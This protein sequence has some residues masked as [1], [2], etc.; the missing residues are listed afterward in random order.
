M[1][2]EKSRP[3]DGLHNGDEHQPKGSGVSVDVVDECSE[4][5][6]EPDTPSR[7]RGTSPLVRHVHIVIRDAAGDLGSLVIMA[8]RWR[9]ATWRR[10]RV[11]HD[12][13]RRDPCHRTSSGC[14]GS[15]TIRALAI[16]TDHG[17]QSWPPDPPAEP[18]RQLRGWC[19]RRGRQLLPTR[20]KRPRWQAPRRG[21]P[22]R[23]RTRP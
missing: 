14:I 8:S 18:G 7:T 4:E 6:Q 17:P 3:N 21:H 5:A 19:G 23:W 15:W 16:H 9:A 22:P 10:R 12:R 11:A 2:N 13:L 1:V 20:D